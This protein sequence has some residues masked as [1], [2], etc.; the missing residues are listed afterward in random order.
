M[1]KVFFSVLIIY[2]LY[3][4]TM[5]SYLFLVDTPLPEAYIGT[6]ADPNTFMNEEQLIL[7][8]DF[9]KWR[10]VLYFVHTPFEWLIYLFVIC[11]GISQFFARWS[12]QLIK[13]KFFQTALYVILL[14]CLS[15]LI[16]FPIK[17]VAYSISKQYG[18]SI[19]TF[20]SWMKDNLIGFWIEALLLTVVVYVIMYLISKSPKRWWLYTWLLSIPFTL[21]L[22]FIQPVVIDPLYNE[23]YPIQDKELEEEILQLANQVDIPADR[24]YEVK[25]SEKTNALNAYVTGI[26]S[27]LR[28]VLWDTTLM[29]LSK[30]E[31]LFVM[32][33]EMGH[34]DLN[35]LKQLLI[36]M[37]ALSFVGLFITSKLYQFTINN[38][39][40]Q[41]NLKRNE[42]AAIPII[43][44]ILSLLSF[45]TSPMSNAISRAYEYQADRY[46][47][48]LTDEPDAAVATFHK[49]SV[50]GL[51]D[52]NPPTIVK[53]FR[54][55]HPPMV[56]R[57]THIR[58]Y[59]N[60][61]DKTK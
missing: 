9:S 35:H 10:N 44:L 15:F 22:M 5:S 45:T 11:F 13:F 47:I 61:I 28:I 53:L 21:F 48:D 43:L 50:E 4:V 56:E 33:H 38:V 59:R 34:Y 26:G 30:E 20:E 36:G 19:Q 60:E 3:A 55:T 31:V 42:M 2:L 16:T 27:N 46:A 8:T 24:V 7:S 25:M 58:E 40:K 54:Y 23:F 12:K 29:S 57:I 49:L 51:A 1:K 52:V 37:I 41:L 18:I 6:E 32:A 14:S 39:G 17:Y